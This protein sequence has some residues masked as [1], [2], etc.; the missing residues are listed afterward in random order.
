MV[1]LGT[2][3]TK[4]FSSS[5]DAEFRGRRKARRKKVKPIDYSPD[6]VQKKFH[7]AKNRKKLKAAGKALPNGSY[8]IAD[9]EDL[10]NAAILARSGHGDVSAAKRLITRRA[11]ELG[12]PN[13]LAK[14]DDV[15]KSAD[16]FTPLS[17]ALAELTG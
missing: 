9:T 7:S 3:P 10:K 16:G 8:P 15:Q 14:Q 17:S 6:A 11:G 4:S 2:I 13:P 1:P 12:V 5:M